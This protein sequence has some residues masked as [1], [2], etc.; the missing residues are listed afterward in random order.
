MMPV[1]RA[2]ED[3]RQLFLVKAPDLELRLDLRVASRHFVCFLACDASGIADS[4]ISAAARNLLEAGAVYFCVWGPECERVHDLIDQVVR[5][6]LPDEDDQT[7]I[8]T[9]WHERESLDDALWFSVFTASAA[10][11]YADSCRA[12]VAIVVANGNW[13]SHVKAR[14][15]DPSRFNAEV[16]TK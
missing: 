6:Q 3:N 14:L 9:T 13:T 5:E 12:L 15:E 10:D 1:G 16:L 11:A 8:M 4:V 7:V 2:G